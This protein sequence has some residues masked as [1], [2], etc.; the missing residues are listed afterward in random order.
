MLF[1]N[2]PN[3]LPEE[4]DAD[5]PVF[6]AISKNINFLNY[7][8]NL[9]INSDVVLRKFTITISNRKFESA[10]LFIDGLV[11][12]DSINEAILSPLLLKNSIK[13]QFSS[14]KVSEV[15]KFDLK[16]FLLKNILTQN[17][18]KIE[19]NFKNVF[20]KVNSGFCALFVDTLSE[21]ICIEVKDFKTRAVEPPKD[22]TVIRGAHEG[23][24]ENLRTNTSLIRKI[25]NNENLIIEN[26]SVRQSIKHKC[27]RVLHEKYC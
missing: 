4:D 13:M 12:N 1:Q 5:T 10:L 6:S 9:L 21:A 8:Y 14:P 16:E 26:L 17:S 3:N 7:K 18:I 22:E 11:D 19:N 25:V 27:C 20:S 23:F 24:N 2:G 15:K